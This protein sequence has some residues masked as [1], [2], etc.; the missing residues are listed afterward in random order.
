V[1]LHAERDALGMP[2]LE[3]RVQ[4]TELDFV[5][6]LEMHRLLH[7]R[8]VASGVGEFIYREEELRARLVH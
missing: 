2:R 6:V 8:F 4:F 7:S 3:A 1:L 5:T